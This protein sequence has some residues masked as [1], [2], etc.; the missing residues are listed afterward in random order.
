MRASFDKKIDI[1]NPIFAKEV[2]NVQ[3]P[4]YKVEAEIIDYYDIPPLRDTVE[5]LQQ[6]QETF[7]NL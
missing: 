7:F 1:T 5:T 3:I 2:L 4:A 6:S